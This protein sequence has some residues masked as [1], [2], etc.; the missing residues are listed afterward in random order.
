MNQAVIRPH[1]S[2]TSPGIVVEI[3]RR[4]GIRGICL[5]AHVVVAVD[6]DERD[7]PEL[8]LITE[9]FLCFN[10]VRRATLLQTTLDNAI[11]LAGSAQ[12][13][14]PVDVCRDRTLAP[15]PVRPHLS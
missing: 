5:R 14:R 1:W 2:R 6:L 8:V 3:R 10:Q 12:H 9:S 15:A 11:V 13:C 4:R 7:L